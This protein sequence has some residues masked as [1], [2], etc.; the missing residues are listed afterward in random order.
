MPGPTIWQAELHKSMHKAASTGDATLLASLLDGGGNANFEHYGNP[1][2]CVAARNNHPQC[3][4]LL[5]EHGADATSVNVAGESALELATV[6]KGEAAE[7][8]VRLLTQH[9]QARLTAKDKVW[10]K[11]TR[12]EKKAMERVL[13]AARASPAVAR[14]G[15]SL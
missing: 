10:K 12:A 15:T 8:I 9:L 3:V 1:A 13:T 14:T 11:P 5:L 6:G 4:D 2:L 7:T